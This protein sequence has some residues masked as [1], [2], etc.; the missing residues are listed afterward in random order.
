MIALRLAVDNGPTD[1][2]WSAMAAQPE[3]YAPFIR[4]VAGYYL[5]SGWPTDT[6]DCPAIGTLIAMAMPGFTDLTEDEAYFVQAGAVNVVCQC[7]PHTDLDGYAKSW[8]AEGA[9]E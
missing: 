3:R 5:M 4:R 2:A 7:S 8:M 1:K 9:P 6:D